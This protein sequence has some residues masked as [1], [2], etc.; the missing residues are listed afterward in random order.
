MLIPTLAYPICISFLGDLDWGP[1][2][3]GYAGAILLGAAFAG[4]GLFSSALTR[5]QII[6]FIIGLAICFCLT[7]IVQLPGRRHPF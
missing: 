7:L 5:N 6:A 4:I 1:V 2:I 3:G